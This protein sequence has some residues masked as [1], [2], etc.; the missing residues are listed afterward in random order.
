MHY[1]SHKYHKK[2][3][4]I[5]TRISP[6]SI[7]AHFKFKKN[8]SVYICHIFWKFGKI[9]LKTG[10]IIT[11]NLIKN[12]I[13][14]KKCIPLWIL[15]LWILCKYTLYTVILWIQQNF[16]MSLFTFYYRF[17]KI[18]AISQYLLNKTTKKCI[19]F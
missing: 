1:S 16:R 3:L 17:Y 19:L 11:K 15:T 7:C 12:N 18:V 2:V 8:I 5:N 6:N 9:W 14:N 4:E 13:F 10:F